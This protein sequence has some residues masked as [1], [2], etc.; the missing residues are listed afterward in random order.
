MGMHARYASAP[1]QKNICNGGIFCGLQ[2]NQISCRNVQL[3][4]FLFGV[5]V[6]LQVIWLRCGTVFSLL[7]CSFMQRWQQL[8]KTSGTL[9][10][11]KS[12]AVCLIVLSKNR[13][14]TRITHFDGTW[15]KVCF[16]SRMTGHPWSIREFQGDWQLQSYIKSGDNFGFLVGWCTKVGKGPSLY[17]YIYIYMNICWIIQALE[18]LENK[19]DIIPWVIRT[20]GDL[21]WSMPS[22]TA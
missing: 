15:N 9:R 6:E 11:R 1:P 18:K 2:L 14:I 5:M 3:C 17:G 8:Y 12:N 10:T 21:C 19:N 7:T 13:R 20:G 4:F 22:V 16:F